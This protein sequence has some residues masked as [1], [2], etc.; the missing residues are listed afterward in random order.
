SMVYT[1]VYFELTK[2]TQPMATQEPPQA[3]PWLHKKVDKIDYFVHRPTRQSGIHI[4]GLAALCGVDHKAIR[5][6]I[7][8][9]IRSEKAEG[10]LGKIRETP[11]SSI[12]KN[13]EIFLVDLG[14]IS[15]KLNGREVKVI[16]ASVCFDIAYY[17]SS[18][19][20]QE[21]FK[22]VGNM[23]RLGAESFVFYK[24]GFDITEHLQV[25][26]MVVDGIEVL[27]YATQ[28]EVNKT[29]TGE[30]V[31]YTDRKTG[32]CGISLTGLYHL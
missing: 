31:Y 3:D 6:A 22:T 17:Y 25:N 15:P 29:T 11:L 2:G 20:Y 10:T 21:A 26:R 27:T 19:G 30:V 16:L 32:Q 5:S 8:K 28:V 14:K 13:R 7:E 1:W 18:Q 24:T 9:V 12:L 4:R 23:G